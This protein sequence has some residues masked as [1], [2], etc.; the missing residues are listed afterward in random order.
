[1]WDFILTWWLFCKFHNSSMEG[2][3]YITYTYISELCPTLCHKWFEKVYKEARHMVSTCQ[4]SILGRWRQDDQGFEVI[5]SSLN[6]NLW[7]VWGLESGRREEGREGGWGGRGGDGE[8]G[9]RGKKD[10]HLDRCIKRKKLEKRPSEN[11]KSIA[12]A[13]DGYHRAWIGQI[14]RA[15]SKTH[16]SPSMSGL[17]CEWG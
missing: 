8:V 5:L 14:K 1:M 17:G 7:E 2:I 4:T 3:I 10:K 9:R 13:Y 12:I 11:E 15:S 6:V 16:N